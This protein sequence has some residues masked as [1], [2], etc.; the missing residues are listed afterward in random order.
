M[1]R[2]AVTVRTGDMGNEGYDISLSAIKIRCIN[3]T[4]L[5]GKGNSLARRH[6]GNPESLRAAVRE[7]FN[8]VAPAMEEF[9]ALWREGNERRIID[10]ADG[11]P[12]SVETCFRRLIKNGYLS[13]P[14]GAETDP[15]VAA[16][17]Q[18]WEYEPGDSYR[19]IHDAVTRLAH[20]GSWQSAWVTEELEEQASELLYARVWDPSS[21]VFKSAWA[22]L[23]EEA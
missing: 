11:T 4:L 13:M 19:A 10:D 7:L 16:L 18:A 6:V 17:M 15:F 12:L 22:A 23:P 21:P 14:T 2:V 5:R 1:H 8:N 3:A 20:T 9:S